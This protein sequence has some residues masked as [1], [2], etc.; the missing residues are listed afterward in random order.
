MMPC[1]LI[2]ITVIFGKQAPSLIIEYQAMPVNV[3]SAAEYGGQV[4]GHI[5]NQWKLGRLHMFFF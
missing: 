2:D 1:T 4:M 3:V 5:V